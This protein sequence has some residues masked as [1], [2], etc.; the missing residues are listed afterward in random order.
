MMNFGKNQFSNLKGTSNEKQVFEDEWEKNHLKKCVVLADCVQ[1]A[2]MR[3]NRVGMSVI[4]YFYVFNQTTF[5]L[6]TAWQTA[7]VYTDL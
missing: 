2:C 3:C 7:Q 6:Q 1:S 5:H 4:I